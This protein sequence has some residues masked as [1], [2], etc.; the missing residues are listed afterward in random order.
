MP[1]NCALWRKYNFIFLAVLWLGLAA[2]QNSHTATGTEQGNEFDSPQES[3]RQSAEA[4]REFMRKEEASIRMYISDRK[5]EMQRSGTGLFYRIDAPAD[6]MSL[7]YAQPGDEAIYHYRISLL[8]GTELYASA[9]DEPAR[10]R[11]EREQAEIGLHE[12]LQLLPVGAS[13]LF[14]LPSHRAFGVS[15]DQEK[16]PPYTSLVYELKLLEVQQ[17]N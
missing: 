17:I 16:I 15:G 10:L 9:D 11:I 1:T 7:R 4:Y 8:N 14:I 13:G 6:T 12:A 3:H 5:L 2:C